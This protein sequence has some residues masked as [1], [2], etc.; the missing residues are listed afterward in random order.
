MRPPLCVP[1]PLSENSASLV[2][3][4]TSPPLQNPVTQPFPA[5]REGA[6]APAGHHAY[7]DP[8]LSHAESEGPAPSFL[9]PGRFR[10]AFSHSRIS[11]GSALR[12]KTSR[13]ATADTPQILRMHEALFERR[14]IAVPRSAPLPSGRVPRPDPRAITHFERARNIRE[15]RKKRRRFGS[16]VAERRHPGARKGDTGG[17]TAGSGQL[18]GG[19]RRK[20]QS[21][22]RHERRGRTLCAMRL[23]PG[24][25]S[26]RQQVQSKGQGAERR[27]A[28]AKGVGRYAPGESGSR[29]LAGGGRRGTKTH[30]AKRGV[31]RARAVG[32]YAPCA[33]R[34]PQMAAGRRQRARC[35]A[36]SEK[37]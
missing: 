6:S 23:A 22:E 11:P 13:S 12:T 19:R 24:D 8:R 20:A 14:A 30:S 4:D 17:R 21:A 27:A 32:R 1:T 26:R 9:F 7:Q 36:H 28:R 5:G 35:R 31:L 37:R 2:L 25:A 16:P 10:S 33:L 18:A 29:Q 3:P 34:Q 15:A